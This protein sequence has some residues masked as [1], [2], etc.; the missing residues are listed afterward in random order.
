MKQKE[1]LDQGISFIEATCHALLYSPVVFF[2]AL[3]FSLPAPVPALRHSWAFLSLVYASF[4]GKNV[5]I[6]QVL[7][8]WRA[9]KFQNQ[10]LF[11][12]GWNPWALVLWI[13]WYEPLVQACP[14]RTTM[15]ATS[16]GRWKRIWEKQ[17]R[18]NST[19]FF[20][21]LCKP[22]TYNN[23]LFSP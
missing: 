20:T 17:T 19:L 12:L 14:L 13:E 9:S 7:L 1:S 21:N 10:F 23:K 2:Q 22:T 15:K 3:P 8:K 16:A 11:H 4:L 5:R 6:F 18:R